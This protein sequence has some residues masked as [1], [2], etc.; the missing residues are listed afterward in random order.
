MCYVFVKKLNHF[1]LM[2]GR[3][4]GA[5]LLCICVTDQAAVMCCFAAA[6]TVMVFRAPPSVNTGIK[7]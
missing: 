5:C 2:L 4:S 7:R 6:I 3:L 1:A